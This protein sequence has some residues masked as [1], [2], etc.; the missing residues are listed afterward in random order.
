MSHQTA[1]ILHYR[2]PSPPLY[3][4]ITF[5]HLERLKYHTYVK[6]QRD[7]CMVGEPL[8]VKQLSQK[9][10]FKIGLTVNIRKH[11]ETVLKG[12][13]RNGGNGFRRQGNTK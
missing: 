13:R 5:T 11:R 4:I 9:H 7:T 2:Q 1:I 8:H 12:H 3:G 10:E 6:K